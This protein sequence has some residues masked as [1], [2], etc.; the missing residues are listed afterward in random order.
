MWMT[1][2]CYLGMLAAVATQLPT[3][4]AAAQ[5]SVEPSVPALVVT[6][7]T[8]IEISGVQGEVFS[9]ASFQYH[10]SASIGIVR[11]SIRTPS[12]LTTSSS[13]DTVDT[14]GVTITLSV[15]TTAVQLALGTYR[16]PFAFTNVTNGHGTTTR[17]VTLI[18]RPPSSRLPSA[19]IVQAPS[20]SRPPPAR[21]TLTNGG[22]Y[23]LD[24]SGRDLLDD[25]GGRLL[26]Q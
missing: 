10:V 12:W 14:T 7:P 13:F 16:L 18:V 2:T 21:H 26:A 19:G 3:S 25:R 9:P 15:N 11:Y 5:K 23:L 1:L 6:P 4:S 22:G 17:T 20:I 24:G 8:G